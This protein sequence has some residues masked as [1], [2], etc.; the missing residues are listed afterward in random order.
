MHIFYPFL[1]NNKLRNYL[2]ADLESMINC[3][4]I[5]KIINIFDKEYLCDFYP[6]AGI[7]S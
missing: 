2:K 5:C 3:Y 6:Q 7:T 1:F 4:L